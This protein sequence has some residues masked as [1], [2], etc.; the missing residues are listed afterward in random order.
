MPSRP[1][2]QCFLPSLPLE[3]W[4]NPGPSLPRYWLQTFT[5][6]RHLLCMVLHARS[7]YGNRTMSGGGCRALQIGYHSQQ[8]EPPS[9]FVNQDIRMRLSP[10][11]LA[12]IRLDNQAS[13]SVSLGL[14]FSR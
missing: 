10:A 9:R 1:D 14:P 4:L 11:R 12:L 8:T 2:M 13:L 3:F 5:A 7:R 6:T